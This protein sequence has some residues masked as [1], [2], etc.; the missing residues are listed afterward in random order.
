LFTAAA[1]RLA[2]CEPGV[3]EIL[4]E[5]DGNS[6][7]SVEEAECVV[8]EIIK[9]LG[10]EWTD[11]D[12]TRP[13]GPSD[14]LVVAAYNA[15]V[16][17][18][19]RQLEL[20]GIH[21][22]QVGTVDKFQGKQAPVVFFSLAVSSADDVPRGISFLLNRNRVNVAVSRA[23]FATYIVRSMHLTD[24]LPASPSGLVELGAFMGV[25]EI[26]SAGEGIVGI[27]KGETCVTQ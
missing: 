9:L 25:T 10:S 23:K 14:V 7:D 6:T 1:R 19:R 8:A 16:L 22:V 27:G 18:I 2:G 21:E 17:R 11:E 20:A 4:V 26:A 5:H 3:H 13:L 24:Y 12:G 15:H